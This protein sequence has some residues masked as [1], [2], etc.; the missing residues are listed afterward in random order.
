MSSAVDL[1]ALSCS[2]DDTLRYF[3]KD[4]RDDWYP[5]SL[6]YEDC[7]TPEIAS[8]LLAQAF[9]RGHG[10]YGPETRTELNIPKK[11]FVLRYSLET[12][13]ADR[14]YYQALVGHLVPFFDSLLAPEILSYRYSAGSPSSRYLFKH[15]IAQW[16]QFKGYVSLEAR[17]RP[18]IL[19]TDIQNYYENLQVA[20]AID[21]FARHLPELPIPGIEKASIRRVLTE[22]GR[23][24]S[25]W[26][27]TPQAG[28]PQNRDASS[29][30][31]NMV[32]QPVDSSM[33]TAGYRYFR[34]V[35]DIRIATVDRYQARAALQQ[36]TTELRKLGLGLNAAKTTIW[37]PGDEGYE[38]EAL[39]QENP[40]LDQISNMWSAR[41]VPVLRRS[42]AP[43][44]ALAEQLIASGGTDGRSFR[45][46]THRF[47]SLAL[48]KELA[49]PKAYFDPLIA[50][51]VNAIDSQPFSSDSLVRFLKAS[52]ASGDQLSPLE[53]FLSDD[54]RAIYDW[55]N[56]LLWQLFVHKKYR[57][58]ELLTVARER[59]TIAAR[60]AD[61]AGALL[62]L[63][64]AGTDDDRVSVVRRF[65]LLESYIVQR[66]ALIALHEID[67]RAGVEAH[68]AP[69]VLPSLKGTYRRLR[70]GFA[71]QYSCPLPSIP[72]ARLYDEASS[73][74]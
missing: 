60:P 68:V 18:V 22:L 9:E 42:L 39:G 19:V 17:V 44:Q 29:F 64:Y 24:L 49:V 32:M 50:L 26:C 30:I 33:L 35:D 23:C 38:T 20:I 31:A 69:Y 13:L 21:S 8:D 67:F 36:L 63:G 47:E 3:R 43:L 15:P 10:L 28:I 73:Y 58:A 56:Y 4:M 14:L 57:S 12:S 53:S 40:L 41:S 2:I 61:Q 46:C 70:S 55:Q 51:C 71:G 27:Y 66:N 6:G 65:S 59:A 25:S 34:Y 7:L 54:R 74:D 5:D 72:A 1:G 45:F 37:E 48:C 16:S 52:P 11:G 62:Y